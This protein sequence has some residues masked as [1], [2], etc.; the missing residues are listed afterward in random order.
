MSTLL[1]KLSVKKP[2]SV[3]SMLTVRLEPL[4]MEK[5]NE[6]SM[7]VNKTRSSIIKTM[8]EHCINDLV[9]TDKGDI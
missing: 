1:D 4:M 8:L 5:L 2:I 7:R 6:I 3:G 9:I